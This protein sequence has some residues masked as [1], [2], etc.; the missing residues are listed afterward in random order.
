MFLFFELMHVERINHLSITLDQLILHNYE[1]PIALHSNRDRTLSAQ[2]S[3]VCIKQVYVMAVSRLLAS[4]SV[5]L[6]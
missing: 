2:S 5:L 6:P 4:E 3:V 1:S